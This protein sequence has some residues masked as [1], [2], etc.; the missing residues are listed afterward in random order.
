MW[1]KVEFEREVE[2]SVFVVLFSSDGFRAL[3]WLGNF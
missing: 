1:L 3:P 2:F